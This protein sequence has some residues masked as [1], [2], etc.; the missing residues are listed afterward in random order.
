MPSH[1][2]TPK[3]QHMLAFQ[4][5]DL[6]IDEGTLTIGDIFNDFKMMIILIGK[7]IFFTVT[8]CFLFFTFGWGLLATFI[9]S[10]CTKVLDRYSR[11]QIFDFLTHITIGSFLILSILF[12]FW[13]GAIIN[14]VL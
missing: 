8:I 7:V 6:M 13:P 5:V 3:K 14:R 4:K 1:V 10:F 12:Y 9:N 2:Y 11:Q